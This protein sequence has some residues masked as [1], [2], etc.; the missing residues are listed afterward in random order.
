MLPMESF[1]HDVMDI[2]LDGFLK[3]KAKWAVSV[4]AMIVRAF[5][6]GLITEAQYSEL[7][8]QISAKGWRRKRGEPLDDLVPIVK[9]SLGQRSLELLELNKIMHA[10][11]IPSTLPM[12][13]TILCDVFQSNPETFEPDELGK[14]IAVDFKLLPKST[15]GVM[16]ELA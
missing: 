2:S 6:L 10:W 1:G 11:E 13:T 3:L 14:V 5:Q 15:Q 7:F 12:P 9:R 4:Q 8:R 16:E